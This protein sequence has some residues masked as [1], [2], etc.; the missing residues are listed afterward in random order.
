[1]PVRTFW[2]TWPDTAA[3][4]FSS[5]KTPKRSPTSSWL[6]HLN[7]CV[8]AHGT[9]YLSWQYHMSTLVWDWLCLTFH[10]CDKIFGLSKLLGKYEFKLTINVSRWIHTFTN[11]INFRIPKFNFCAFPFRC[12]LSVVTTKFSSWSTLVRRHLCTKNSTRPTFW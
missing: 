11:I 7:R 10:I 6:M 5:F 9:I 1:M 8:R 12:G 3:T 4:G 2:F